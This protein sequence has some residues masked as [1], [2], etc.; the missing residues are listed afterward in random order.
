MD[1]HQIMTFDLRAYRATQLLNLHPYHPFAAAV[2]RGSHAR[3]ALKTLI[4]GRA[5]CPRDHATPTQ[6]PVVKALVKVYYITSVK[7]C[8]RAETYRLNTSGKKKKLTHDMMADRASR[9]VNVRCVCTLW[10]SL[11]MP[12]RRV[13]SS[14]ITITC[15]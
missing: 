7:A 13:R 9:R 3:L 2:G 1:T 15:C 8:R 4:P 14:D 5:F 10:T 11:E 12:G 6:L